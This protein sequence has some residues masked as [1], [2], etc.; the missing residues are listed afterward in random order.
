MYYNIIYIHIHTYIYIHIY[1]YMKY[2]VLCG[3]DITQI[4]KI[5]KIKALH[6]IR[7]SANS[8]AFTIQT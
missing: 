4:R 7:S 5:T 3:V 2:K 8:M 1:T 6:T